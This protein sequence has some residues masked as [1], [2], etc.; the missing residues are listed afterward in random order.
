M[1]TTNA[2]LERP[3][4]AAAV[5]AVLAQGLITR[6]VGGRT[7]IGWG[8]AGSPPAVE[9]STERLDALIEHNVG[10]FTAVMQAGLQLRDAQQT[11]AASG[12]R[13]ALDPPDGEGRA[14]VGGVIATGDSGPLRH[15]YGAVRDLILGVQVA[16]PDGTVARAGSRVIKNVAGYDLAKLMCGAFGT[17]GVICEVIMRLHPQ[18]TGTVTV[19]ARGPDAAT[20]ARAASAVRRRPFEL[21]ALDA[22]WD[23][24]GAALLAQAAGRACHSAAESVAQVVAGEG[25]EVEVVDNDEQ[26]WAAQRARQ[27]APVGGAVVRVSFPP[28]E[29]GRVVAAAPR[30]VA[31]AGVG[32][33]WVE[34][35]P[36]PDALSA[37]RAELAP[38]PCV[39]LDAPDSLRAAV[40]VWGMGESPQLALMERV[41]AR[42]DPDGVCNRGRFVGGL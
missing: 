22:V 21:E 17:L 12:Q 19:V 2:V 27:R 5:A 36:D 39:L 37:L 28:G 4:D 40:D 29:L 23:G 20:L 10:D 42:F 13:L 26:L 32:L 6:P 31:R 8:A 18:P 3:A 25:L 1:A 15:R 30:A 34:V 41:K 24:D 16:L 38:S 11:F 14:T 9:L 35:E 7:K 33:A